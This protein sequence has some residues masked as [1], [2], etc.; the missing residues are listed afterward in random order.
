MS[1]NTYFV[2]NCNV[3]ALFTFYALPSGGKSKDVV[4][5]YKFGNLNF[6]FTNHILWTNFRIQKGLIFSQK[7][8]FK[9]EQKKSEFD[10]FLKRIWNSLNKNRW[11]FIWIRVRVRFLGIIISHHGAYS[12]KIYGSVNYGTIVTAKFWP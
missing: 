1:A 12:I 10:L 3:L 9:I 6:K 8:R 2:L 11:R 4:V 7:N 5:N